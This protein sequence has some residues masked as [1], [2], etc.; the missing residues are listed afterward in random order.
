M[1]W[2]W[3][4]IVKVWEKQKL[5]SL[6]ELK[7]SE[8]DDGNKYI[9]FDFA[10]P[11]DELSMQFHDI[12]HEATFHYVRFYIRSSISQWLKIHSL[13]ES[14]LPSFK[15]L[16]QQWYVK[17]QDIADIFGDDLAWSKMWSIL[18]KEF[19]TKKSSWM[20]LLEEQILDYRF[21][22][23]EDEITKDELESYFKKGYI[24]E[25]LFQ[26]CLVLLNKVQ[27]DIKKPQATIEAVTSR[28]LSEYRN[29][30]NIGKLT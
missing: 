10:K 4:W 16:V 14:N 27:E 28:L 26:K 8:K 9:P 13:K 30:I 15:S 17:I 21:Y 18:L 5:Y 24:T 7:N 11:V 19:I 6:S 29:I 25:M 3:Y 22:K 20:T 23:K 1:V 2:P 12:W